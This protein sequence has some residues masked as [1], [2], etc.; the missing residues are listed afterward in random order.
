MQ[1]MTMSHV[2]RNENREP[3]DWHNNG[4]QTIINKFPE[5]NMR[6]RIYVQ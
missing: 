3:G 6:N 5:T 2:L 4:K 1:K